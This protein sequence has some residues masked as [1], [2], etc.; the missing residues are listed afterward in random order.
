MASFSYTVW[1]DEPFGALI[2]KL[3][4]AFSHLNFSLINPRTGRLHVWSEHGDEI[5]VS[6]AALMPVSELPV[7][8]QWWRDEEDVFVSIDQE[9]TVGGLFCC[10]RLVGLSRLEE[11]EIGRLLILHVLPG[12]QQFPEDFDVFR[13]ATL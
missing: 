6:E 7:G 8:I 10:V 2:G 13:V 3:Q 9:K 4:V 1:S 5:A 11:A 12:K